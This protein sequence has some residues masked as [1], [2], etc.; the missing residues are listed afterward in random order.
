MRQ[1]LR[2]RTHARSIAV[3][4]LL[5]GLPLV[6]L[7]GVLRKGHDL[8]APPPVDGTWWV[9]VGASC[10]LSG[11][12]R[13]EIVQ[14]GQYVAVSLADREPLQGRFRDGVLR[15]RGGAR[16][17]FAPGCSEGQ[18]ELVLRLGEDAGR[19]EGTGG[20]EGCSACPPR[21]ISAVRAPVL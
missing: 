17:S 11:G 8:E 16:E 1:R 9:N 3:Y 6:G 15:A 2:L 18:V 14:S 10:G 4:A 13:L 20:I 12:E 7:L 5:V 19:L 21:P